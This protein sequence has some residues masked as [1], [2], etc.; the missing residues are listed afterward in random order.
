MKTIFHKTLQYSLKKTISLCKL[1]QKALSHINQSQIRRQFIKSG[2][3]PWSCG[4]IEYR[5]SMINRLLNDHTQ[6]IK[7]SAPITS[8]LPEGFGFGLDERC[9]EW[10]WA[11]ANL[12]SDDKVIMDAGSAL[13]HELILSLP[14]WKDRDL[15]IIT[16]APEETCQWWRGISYSYS[17]LRHLP[18]RDNWFDAI[19]S[20]STLEHVGLDNSSV[21][22]NASLKEKSTTDVFRAFSE[23]RRALRPGGRLLFTVPFGKYENHKFFQQFDA[24]LLKEAANVFSPSKMENTFFRYTSKGWH[25]ANMN[26][27]TN[28]SFAINALSKIVEPDLAAAAR[29]VACCIWTK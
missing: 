18:F 24:H 3:A 21:S 20:I 16:L 15:T 9:V 13:N 26:E 10:P 29:A 22:N 6:L 8:S 27:C 25:I 28:E 19:I 5:N 4:Y 17:D 7:F 14:A 12:R 2:L 1:T 23:L 11:M